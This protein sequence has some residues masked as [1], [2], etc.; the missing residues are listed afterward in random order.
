[1]ALQGAKLAG[2]NPTNNR[3]ENDFYATNPVAVGKLLAKYD[4][5]GTTML[6]P[7]VGMGHI[8]YTVSAI[9]HHSKNIEVTALDI[10]D[11]GYPDTI[12]QNFLTWETDKKFEMIISNPPYSLGKEFIEKGMELL[13]E[14]G[15]M[16]MF[17]KIQ[18]LEGAKRK[19]LFEKYPP[20]YIYVF[21]NRMATFN[22]GEP[23]DPNGKKWA[24][25]MC[26]AWFVW[27][28]GSTSEP[29]VRWID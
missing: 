5:N 20:K 27:E 3:V 6:E 12:V 18:F 22:N 21:R 7:C 17:L 19:E 11:R 28:K 25:T 1:M 4:F 15:Q 13:T 24:T 29:I 14:N 10:V 16:A 2:G 26:H 23:L 9:N 8:A